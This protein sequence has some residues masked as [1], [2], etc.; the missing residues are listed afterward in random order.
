MHIQY[1]FLTRACCSETK[2]DYNS[3]LTHL[4]SGTVH[5]S[6]INRVSYCHVGLK[7]Y[8]LCKLKASIDE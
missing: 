2:H 8:F 6:L 7:I 5:A 3:Q 4:S 1:T